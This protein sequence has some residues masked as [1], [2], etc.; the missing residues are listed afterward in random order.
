[1]S[2]PRIISFGEVLWDL[3]PDGARFGGAPANF[4]SHAALLGGDVSMVSAVGDDARG[5]EAIQILGALGVGTPTIQVI[6]GS[7][8]GTVGV[9]TNAQGKP[10]YS[11]HENVAWD[12][13]AWRPELK[14]LIESADAVYF[15]TLGQRNAPSRHTIR[16]ALEVAGANNTLRVLDINLRAPFFDDSIIRESIDRADLLKFSDEELAPIMAA[17][18]L[19]GSGNALPRLLE[20]FNLRSL[21]MTRGAE[22]AI[23]QSANGSVE[24]AGIAT[25]IVDTVGA[26]DAFTAAFVLSTLQGHLVSEILEQAN[27]SA[28]AVCA[29]PGA[30]AVPA[31][32]TN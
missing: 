23:Y 26:G 15:G 31:P 24:Q 12:Q 2:A 28:A 10:T 17:G 1:M 18:D 5:R 3:F 22:G 21:V 8:T 11:I 19:S 7:L 9:E 6:P 14:S 20:R 30:I 13:M 29:H 25:E 4:A 16:R 32:S 27:R